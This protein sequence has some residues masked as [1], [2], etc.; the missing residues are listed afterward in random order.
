MKSES[1]SAA[2]SCTT[3][4]QK[5]SHNLSALSFQ[6]L[7][8]AHPI[9]LIKCALHNVKNKCYLWLMRPQM[10][11]LSPK[12]P[13]CIRATTAYIHARHVIIMWKRT[14]LSVNSHSFWL[15]VM[16]EHWRQ[17][18]KHCNTMELI[19]SG[20]RQIQSAQEYFFLPF[21]V[22]SHPLEASIKNAHLTNQETLTDSSWSL[23]LEVLLHHPHTPHPLKKCH[24]NFGWDWVFQWSLYVTTYRLWWKE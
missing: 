23:M 6:F 3:T 18:C 13:L 14:H 2:S 7:V 24:F 21:Q 12:F 11:T 20:L 1:K 16:A 9:F 22:H 4:L 19:W 5:L 10:L 17:I 8:T 15:D